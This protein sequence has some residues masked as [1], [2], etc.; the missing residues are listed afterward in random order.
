MW[1][2]ALLGALLLS[3]SALLWYLFGQPSPFSLE[4]VRPKEPQEMDQKKRNKV[5]KKGFSMDRVPE[6]LDAI[7]IGSGLGGMTTAACLAKA[8]KKVLVLEQHDQ[9]GGCT[10]TFIEKGFEFDVGL[11]YIGQLHERSFL[12][13]TFDQITEGQLEF[14]TLDQHFDHIYIGSGEEHRQYSMYYGKEEMAAHLKKQFPEDTKAIETFFKVMKLTARRIHLLGILKLIPRW[15]ALFLLKST[16]ADRYCPIFRLAVTGTTDWA[17]HLTSNKDLQ[18]VF[19][20]LFIGVPPRDASVVLNALFFHHYKRGAYYPKGGASEVPFHI[21]NTIRKYGGEVLVRAPVTEILLD[22]NGAACG[23]AVRKGQT[24]VEVRAPIVISNCGLYNTFNKLLPPQIS[25]KHN[26]QSR[27]KDVKLSKGCLILFCGFDGTAEEL[28]IGQTTHWLFKGN[29]TDKLMDEFYGMSKDEAPENVPNMFV[30]FPSVKDTSSHI[31]HP[32][33]SCMT[34]VTMVNYEWFEEWKD[35]TVRKRGDDYEQY[36]M[37]FAN[38]MFDWACQF[39]PKLREKRVFMEVSSPLSNKHYLA[40]HTGATYGVEH[41]L[42]RFDPIF[43]ANN[44]S[45]T[46]IKNLY[47]SGQDVFSCG[48]AGVLHG[49]LICASTVLNQI[50]YVDLLM[51]K[52]KLKG[53]NIIQTVRKMFL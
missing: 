8:G 22:S 5:L 10:H 45:D 41:D 1:L 25:M 30:T 31:R 28:G 53:S 20:Y 18:C 51:L 39:F 46:P 42:K 9:A 21:S 3:I 2:Q 34:I 44:R 38:H 52:N 24:E 4:S 43:M 29:D 27:V 37:R 35:G 48:I 6:N 19:S 33:K 49:G 47:L 36:K 17:N 13:I 50:L 14:V 11:H 7:I 26:I 12:K 32:G 23:V 40:S 15:L 16:L